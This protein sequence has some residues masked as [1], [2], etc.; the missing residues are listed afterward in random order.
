VARFWRLNGEPLFDNSATLRTAWSVLF[1]CGSECC[2]LGCCVNLHKFML[3]TS[4]MLDAKTS[5]VRCAFR[6]GG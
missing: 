6:A 1:A 5:E 4:S 3:R 2:L